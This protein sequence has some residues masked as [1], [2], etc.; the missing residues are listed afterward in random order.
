MLAGIVLLFVATH[1]DEVK[2]LISDLVNFLSALMGR[3]AKSAPTAE[4]VKES[5]SALETPRRPF[6][7]FVNPFGNGLQGW[8]GPQI[9][10]HTFAALEAWAAARGRV[11]PA[12]QTAE[13]FARTLV[14]NEPELDRWPLQAAAM[15]DRVMFAGWTPTREQVAALAEL[16]SRMENRVR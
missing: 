4:E 2:R 11:R 9:V 16:W 15:L 1:F 7:S 8:Q 14:L 12:N 10:Q 13:E 3:N 5:P 6:S